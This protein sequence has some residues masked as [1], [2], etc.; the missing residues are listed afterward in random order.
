MIVLAC[1]LCVTAGP[2]YVWSQNVFWAS[3][4]RVNCKKLQNSNV[5]AYQHE[6]K[7]ICDLITQNAA[8]PIHCHGLRQHT[9]HSHS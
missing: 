1:L 4:S 5:N 8:F 6:L 9:V 7:H 2:V 3:V